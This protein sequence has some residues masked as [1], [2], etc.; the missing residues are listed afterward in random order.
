MGLFNK[1]VPNRANDSRRVADVNKH[2]IPTIQNE[3]PNPTMNYQRNMAEYFLKTE[4]AAQQGPSRHLASGS[5]MPTPPST[6]K[7]PTPPRKGK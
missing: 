4:R 1:F 2:I 3:Q 7:M 5:R 6:G